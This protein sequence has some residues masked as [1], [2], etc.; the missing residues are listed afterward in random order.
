MG[1][2]AYYVKSV[3]IMISLHAIQEQVKAVVEELEAS[4]PDRETDLK[5]ARTGQHHRGIDIP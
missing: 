5:W 2:V 3:H 4:L 1:C